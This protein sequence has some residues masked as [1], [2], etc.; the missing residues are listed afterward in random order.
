MSSKLHLPDIWLQS[1]G[2]QSDLE[3][4]LAKKFKTPAGLFGLIDSEGFTLLDSDGFYVKV[5]A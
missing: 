2:A 1:P 5:V 3:R 4:A